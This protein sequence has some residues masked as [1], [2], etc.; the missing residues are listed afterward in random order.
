MPADTTRTG[1]PASQS[2]ATSSRQPSARPLE[3]AEL[4]WRLARAMGEGRT[5]HDPFAVALDLLRAARH[6]PATMAHALTLGRTHLRVHAGDTAARAG[7][8][9]LEGAIVFL[10]VKPRTGEV[11]THRTTR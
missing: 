4:V 1:A 2:G 7:A 11:T 3:T 5:L 10:G 9:L 8:R 6:D